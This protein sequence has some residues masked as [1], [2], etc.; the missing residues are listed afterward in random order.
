MADRETGDKAGRMRTYWNLWQAES[1]KHRL[2]F[3]FFML[4][5]FG[6]RLGYIFQPVRNDEAYTYLA[7]AMHPLKVVVSY[8]NAPNNHIFHSILVHF[9]T[10]VFGNNLFA[11]RLPVFL[12]G[13]VVVPLTYL[14]V[15]KLSNRS[16]ALLAMG[17]AAVSSGLINY[18]T[19]A[20]GYEIQALLLLVLLLI[21][22]HLIRTNSRWGWVAFAVVSALGLYTVPSFIYFFP[23][24][25]LWVFLS[26]MFKH[27]DRKKL[28]KRSLASLGGI[29]ALTFLLY[30]PVIVASGTDTF[31]KGDIRVNPTAVA[32]PVSQFLKLAP[33][34]LREIWTMMTV[35]I[36]LVF[37]ITLL[38]GA[39]VTILLYKHVTRVGL[40]LPLV[41][42]V[43][44]AV[45]YLAQRQIMFAR[46]F[47][48]LIP[49]FLGLAAIGLYNV[50]VVIRGVLKEAAGF[51]A[52]P[53]LGYT[54]LGLVLVTLLYSLVFVTQGPYQLDEVGVVEGSFREASA[55]VDLL[56]KELK[57]GDMVICAAGIGTTPLE[58]YFSQRGIPLDYLMGN[59]V[60]QKRWNENHADFLT[61]NFVGKD[62]DK[63]KRAIFILAQREG[64]SGN[65]VITYATMFMG[66]DHWNFSEVKALRDTPWS[67]VLV[68]DRLGTTPFEGVTRT[69]N[70]EQY[71]SR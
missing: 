46:V 41:M 10:R 19:Q 3:Y 58:Y 24:V 38:V 32:Y 31:F 11:L 44:I 45:V 27:Y 61:R 12:A 8:Y 9:S 26:R 62:R 56:Q 22:V 18:S 50:W 69:V 37:S 34:N 47:V 15:R 5:G 43:W 59:V 68:C 21:G 49:V 2:A 29:I 39:L 17:L 33:A 20:R 54:V 28:V 48:P 66:F 30:I 14:F 13:I 7:F 71:Q 23:G 60:E 70:V 63:I 65:K 25:M 57:P 6:L 51:K 36:P 40:N 16:A 52:H 4:L 42:I 1:L 35:G 55:V 67:E 64:A 53:A